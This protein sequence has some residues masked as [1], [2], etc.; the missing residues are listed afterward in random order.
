MESMDIFESRDKIEEELKRLN[1]PLLISERASGNWETNACLNFTFDKWDTYAEGYRVAG[2]VLVQHVEKEK[3]HQ[4]TLVYP[5]MFLYRQYIELRLKELIKVSGRLLDKD[6]KIPQHHDLM[7]LWQ[8]V[9][10]NLEAVWSSTETKDYHD[11]AEERLKEFCDI[12]R[13]SFAFRYPEDKN[14][15]P[16][17]RGLQHINLSH[18]SEVMRAISHLLDGSSLGLGEYLQTKC[19]MMAEY[20]DYEQEMRAEM[21]AEYRQYEREM[22]ADY[23]ENEQG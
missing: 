23:Y 8:K 21:M 3:R 20:G 17:L 9:R 5:I 13:I 10:P 22:M 15:D 2:D 18:L 14:G 1:D 7:L 6:P 19:E 11:A 16:T 12:D 4:D